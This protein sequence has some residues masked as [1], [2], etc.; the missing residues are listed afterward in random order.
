MMDGRA[1]HVYRNH[2]LVDKPI[3]T[4][5]GNVETASG[6]WEGEGNIRYS[7]L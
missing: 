2:T 1:P 7:M 4:L 3:Q 5:S 6:E